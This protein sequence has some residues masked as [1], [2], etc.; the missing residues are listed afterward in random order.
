MSKSLKDKQTTVQLLKELID[1]HDAIGIANIESLPAPQLQRMRT[2]LRE[3]M[4]L[5]V[6]KKTL[7]RK[8]FE[9]AEQKPNV[10]LLLDKMVGMPALLFTTENPFKL[11]S[12]LR[13][14]KSKAPAKTGQLAPN[15]LIIPAGPT[16]FGPG[17]IISDLGSIG[18]KTGVENGKVTVKAEAVV[19]KEGEAIS[20]NVANV[21]AK[22]GM[23]P[24]E[25]GLN[26]VAVYDAG[27]LYDKQVLSVDESHYRNQLSQAIK[28]TLALALSM[29]YA[30]PETIRLMIVK[31]FALARSLAIKNEILSDESIK[32]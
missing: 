19:A 3:T 9:I 26:L 15:D 16:P 18:L 12:I 31:A 1:S 13:K 2:T 29:D 24:M 20:E 17:P 27:T 11:A 4:K 22:L 10:K 21:L 5:V 6:A 14:N 30:T 7:I 28:D 25:I 32:Q 8:A 23:E